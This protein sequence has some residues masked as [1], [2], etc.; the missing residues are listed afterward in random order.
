[1]VLLSALS[2]AV[3]VG[4][5]IRV[6]LKPRSPSVRRFRTKTLHAPTAPEARRRGAAR[7]C[8]LLAEL[9][10]TATHYEQSFQHAYIIGS[11][12]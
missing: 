6:V 3:S 7:C 12:P 2:L 9:L 1:M 4:P 10:R 8:D 11:Q 5:D